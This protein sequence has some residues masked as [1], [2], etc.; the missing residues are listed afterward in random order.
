MKRGKMER[1]HKRAAAAADAIFK[2]FKDFRGTPFSSG[3]H[4]GGSGSGIG[5]RH[6]GLRRYS[7]GEDR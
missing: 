6:G 7:M 5:S 1:R 4:G 2:E 3:G